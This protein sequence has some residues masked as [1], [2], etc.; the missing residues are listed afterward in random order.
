MQVSESRAYVRYKKSFKR[1]ALF[2]NQID[3]TI[4]LLKENKESPNLHFKPMTCKRDKFR[5]SIRVLKTDYRIL[6][7][8]YDNKAELVC[9]CNHD[10]YDREN[11]NC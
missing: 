2:L 11:K 5:Y 7:T 8:F 6:L 3:A 9:V 4:K 10:R 1:D